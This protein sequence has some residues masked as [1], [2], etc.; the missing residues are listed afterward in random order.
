M[1]NKKV[2]I[3]AIIAVIIIAIVV[4]GVM[5]ARFN[6]EQLQILAEE[7]D[8]LGSMDI[9]TEN[10]DMEIKSKGKYAVV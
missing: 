7:A 2:V 6:A 1:K 8:K 9:A 10:I 5:Y 3:I 4:A